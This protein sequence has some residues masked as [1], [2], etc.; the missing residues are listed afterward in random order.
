MD[1]FEIAT[2]FYLIFYLHYS[3][4]VLHWLILWISLSL[5][6]WTKKWT[7]KLKT[8]ILILALLFA[9]IAHWGQ[10]VSFPWLNFYTC[11][12]ELPYHVLESWDHTNVV[13]PW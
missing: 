4:I 8:I 10:L 13:I 7:V 1:M 11:E 3:M 6:V 12:I 9:H 5:A 2:G